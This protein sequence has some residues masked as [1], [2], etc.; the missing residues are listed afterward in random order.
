MVLLVLSLEYW[1]VS[2]S[3]FGWEYTIQ[4]K[5]YLSDRNS[6]ITQPKWRITPLKSSFQKYK[7]IISSRISTIEMKMLRVTDNSSKL[8]LS[9]SCKRSWRKKFKPGMITNCGE[10]TSLFTSVMKTCLTF[11]SAKFKV[12]TMTFLTYSSREV[13]LWK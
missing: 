2:I 10:A 6:V 1:Y 9:V 13:N 7:L 12:I 8:N 11:L 5:R 4:T 3:I